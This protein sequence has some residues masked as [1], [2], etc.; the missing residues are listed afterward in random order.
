MKLFKIIY[1]VVIIAMAAGLVLFG[2]YWMF[3]PQIEAAVRTEEE[4][5][6]KN[7][8]PQASAFQAQTNDAVFY[9]TALN[10][11]NAVIGYVFNT[12]NT[13]YGG[14]VSADVC[15]TNGVVS[16]FKIISAAYETPGLGTK[17]ADPSWSWQF[18]SLTT[19]RLPAGKNEFKTYGLDAISGATLTCMAAI[20]DIRQAFQL[21]Y[22]ITASNT[23]IPGTPKN[24]QRTGGI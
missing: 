22:N 18:Q 2:A 11:S 1:P 4:A 24:P 15:I 12:S 17:A 20:A 7:A 8:F 3:R 16:A 9:Y 19:N 10:S 14:Y 21:Y 13:G 5:A 6:L 23:N